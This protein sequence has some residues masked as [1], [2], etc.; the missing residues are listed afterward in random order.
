M[1]A[2]LRTKTIPDDL[3]PKWRQEFLIPIEYPSTWDTIDFQ[4]F[5]HN[6]ATFD[7]QVAVLTFSI[8]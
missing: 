4:L 6:A 8:K 1:K 2:K 3:T 5:D 7:E